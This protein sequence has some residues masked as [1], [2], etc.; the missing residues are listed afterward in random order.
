METTVKRP[1]NCTN[2][3]LHIFESLVL[4]GGQVS[5]QGLR[6]RIKL[7][8]WL[9]TLSD[10]KC[11][12]VGAIKKPDE[13]YRTRI[14][15]EAGA[16]MKASEYEYEFGWL[17]VIPKARDRRYAHKLI[18]SAIAVL[19][20]SH[21]FA[22]TRTNNRSMNHLLAKYS[23]KQLGSSYLSKDGSHSLTLYVYHPCAT[24]L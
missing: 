3:E 22:T 18:R 13:E 16:R 8:E 21:C 7:A 15:T 5:P 9:I 4:Q 24:I 10:N 12:A 11:L 20:N 23:F 2:E 14:F 19:G 6:R 1:N 17:Y